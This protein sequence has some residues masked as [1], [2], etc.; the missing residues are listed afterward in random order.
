MAFVT[1]NGTRLH[2]ETFGVAQSG[3]API[4]LIHGSTRTGASDWG[5][6]APRLAASGYQVIVPD[7]RGHGQSE[8]PLRTYSFRELADDLAALVPALGFRTAHCIGHS[9]GGNVVLVT[10]IEHSDVVQACVL[11]AANGY[12]SA[13]LVEKEPLLFDAERVARDAPA[14]MEEMQALH[15]PTHGPEYWRDLLRL[16]VQELIS[17]PNYTPADLDGVRRPVLVIQGANDR[18]NATGRHAHYLAEH[19]PGA[20]LWLPEGVGHNVHDERPEEWSAR[21]VDFLARRGGQT[22]GFQPGRLA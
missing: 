6:T 2:F 15:G 16:T 18:V 21:V 5:A 8:N 10:L 19:I 14:W 11:Q 1:V 12:V 20:E 13:D 22:A 7:C 9:N 3:R 4:V 17:E